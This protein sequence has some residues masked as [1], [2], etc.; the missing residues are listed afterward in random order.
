MEY[1][2]RKCGSLKPLPL[3]VKVHGEPENLCLACAQE[4]QKAW[5]AK[6]PERAKVYARAARRKNRDKNYDVP[7]TGKVASLFFAKVDMP[8]DGERVFD[9]CWNWVGRI[10]HGYGSFRQCPAHR[11][12]HVTFKGKISEGLQIDH[13]CRNTRCVNPKH[14][15]AVTGR[16]NVLRGLTIPAA[17]VAKTHCPHGHEYAGANVRRNMKGSRYC[18][19]CKH[20]RDA[21]R[22]HLK[23]IEAGTI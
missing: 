18:V 19:E 20:A 9:E 5:K 17:N 16:E 2:C 21:R 7:L 23:A 1:K 15:E 22:R 12:S 8:P 13:L 6:N 14:L 4:Y 3:M 10:S 11:I